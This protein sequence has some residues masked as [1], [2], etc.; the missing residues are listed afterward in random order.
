MARTPITQSMAVSPKNA[1]ISSQ[2]E[3]AVIMQST[4]AFD[5]Y[6]KAFENLENDITLTY[7]GV[8][9]RKVFNQYVPKKHG[10]LR[11]SGEVI[12]SKGNVTVQWG[13]GLDYAHYQYIGKIY[14]FNHV[15]FRNG[16][17][18]GWYSSSEKK[19]SG[20][21]MIPNAKYTRIL[22]TSGENPWRIDEHGKKVKVKVKNPRRYIVRLGYST[23]NTGHHWIEEITHNSA[24][25]YNLK[26]TMGTYLYERFA[27]MTGKTP[28]MHVSK[29]DW[30]NI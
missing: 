17:V 25:Y 16:L 18:G 8:H 7:L 14:D 4:K 21:T 15:Y 23:P 9:I 5:K 27:N 26:M 13:K 2:C 10:H 29:S 19:D 6:I 11:K 20:R 22:Y 1:F 24:R 3:V 12:T 28:T 30:N